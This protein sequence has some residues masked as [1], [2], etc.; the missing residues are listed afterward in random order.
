MPSS[1]RLLGFVSGFSNFGLLTSSEKFMSFVYFLT[2]VCKEKI[3][4]P[5]R[6]GELY[7]ALKIPSP[8]NFGGEIRSLR[9]YGYL[10]AVRG[11]EFH[12]TLKGKRYI[13]KKLKEVSPVRKSV[14]SSLI[15]LKAKF[16][17]AR[18]REFFDEVLDCISVSANRS[19]LVM[20]WIICIHH[21]RVYVLN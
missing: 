21:L 20:M 10:T 4:T 7:S 13:I 17:D 16:S 12:L 15:S 8:Q 11:P 18:E 19:A 1:I 5:D 14:R 2:E 3:A 6:I 9:G